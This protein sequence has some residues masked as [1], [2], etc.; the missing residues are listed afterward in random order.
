MTPS[1]PTEPGPEA[2]PTVTAAPGG[3]GAL[4][5]VRM[6]PGAQKRLVRGFPW[7]YSN[8]IEMD[9]AAREAPPGGLARLVDSHG[10]AL[11]TALYNR[12]P[13]I[14]ARL[15]SRRSDVTIA[16][17]LAMRIVSAQPGLCLRRRKAGA[18]KQKPIEACPDGKEQ[19][20]SS[21]FGCPTFGTGT[22]C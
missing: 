17:K 20:K 14:A 21:M 16:V 2:A 4:P 15:L 10:A 1:S 22:K 6:K 13:L 7:A 12:R 11:G 5:V 9:E 18:I 8:E 19:Y 3:A